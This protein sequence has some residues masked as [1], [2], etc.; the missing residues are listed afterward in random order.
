MKNRGKNKSVAFII[1]FRVWICIYIYIYIYISALTQIHFNGTNFI[2]AAHIFCL[3]HGPTRSWKNGDAQCCQLSNIADPF[4]NLF[5]FKKTPKPYL[6]SE[7]RPVLPPERK[8]LL[9]QRSHTHHSLYCSL[10]ASAQFLFSAW[11]PAEKGST[12]IQLN[13]YIILLPSLILHY[14]IIA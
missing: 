3:T 7:N 10:S 12:L 2:N 9:S 5:P 1:L 14:A 4:S 13:T 8:V 6:V 11:Q